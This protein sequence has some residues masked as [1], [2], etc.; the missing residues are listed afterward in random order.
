MLFDVLK[1]PQNKMIIRE[2]VY[3]RDGDLICSFD[4]GECYGIFKKREAADIE[5]DSVN[6]NVNESVGVFY[7][8]YGVQTKEVGGKTYT[9]TFEEPGVTTGERNCVAIWR[10]KG[11]TITRVGYAYDVHGNFIGF[12]LYSTNEN[13]RFY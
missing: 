13:V 1:E 8:Y 12:K 2:C 4:I 3:D 7:K 9:S 6:R 5:A 11:Y 10:G